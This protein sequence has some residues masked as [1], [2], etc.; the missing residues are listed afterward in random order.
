ME[1]LQ[2]KIKNGPRVESLK[3]FELDDGTIVAMF[4]GFRG[5]YPE[6]DFI[7]KYKEPIK[8][9][10]TPS[11]THWIVDLLVKAEFNKEMVRDFVQKYLDLYDVMV[12]FESQEERNSYE[13][14]HVG[15]SLTDFQ[16]LDGRGYLSVEFLS[17]IIE[18]FILCEKRSD[19]AFMFK[20]L[21]QLVIDFCDGKRD[22]YQVVGYSKRV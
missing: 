14:Q 7:V 5:S 21:L 16:D 12:P 11:H 17:T 3:Q 13:L 15:E 8:K 18:L 2:Y 10:R 22:Y 20:G 1:K 19:G 9:L 4:Q 6:L